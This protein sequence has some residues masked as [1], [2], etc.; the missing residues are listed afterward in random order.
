[1]QLVI[2]A[3]VF[4]GYYKEEILGLAD[5]QLTGSAKDIFNRL[6]IEDITFFDN[7]G[8]IKDEWRRL[9]DPEWFESWYPSLLMNESAYEIEVESCSELKK[10]L[11][12]FGFPNSK[13]FWYIKTAKSVTK[14]VKKV[15]IITE[16]LD[17][18]NP[19]M[20]KTCR[21]TRNH[22]LTN[23]CDPV[24]RYLQKK[25]GIIINSIATYLT[26]CNP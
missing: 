26:I 17:F 8:N 23:K 1:M 25:E 2:D 20:K 4:E 19:K 22:I 21:K 10:Q 5:N 12:K 9:S 7:K 16:D 24:A 14:K 13:D 6:G 18:Y 15:F 3:N 11:S